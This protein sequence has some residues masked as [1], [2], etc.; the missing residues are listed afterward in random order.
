MLKIMIM[1]NPEDTSDQLWKVENMNR[2]GPV[3]KPD[4]SL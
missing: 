4:I 3:N 1:Q 2:N